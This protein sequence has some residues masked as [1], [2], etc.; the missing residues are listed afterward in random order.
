M[1]DI[2]RAY[3]HYVNSIVKKY[4]R[5]VHKYVHSLHEGAKKEGPKN[6]GLAGISGVMRRRD[7]AA[8][9][10]PVFRSLFGYGGCLTMGLAP[11]RF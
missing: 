7:T 11:V 10:P 3:I 2:I 9:L 4:P 6:A 1:M 8:A 5:A